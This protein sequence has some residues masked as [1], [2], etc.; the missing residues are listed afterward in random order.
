MN[1]P[2]THQ[3]NPSQPLFRWTIARKISGLASVLILFILIIVVYSIA[4]LKKIRADLQEISELDVPL[5][6]I[7]NAIEIHQLEQHIALDKLLE[8]QEKNSANYLN[9][10]RQI[11]QK[12]LENTTQL[13]KQLDE[14][15]VLSNLG[16]QLESQDKF[17]E[18]NR[19]LLVLQ[20][21]SNYLKNIIKEIIQAIDSKNYPDDKIIISL[22]EKDEIIDAQAI[23]L[24]KAVEDFTARRLI[25]AEKHEQTFLIINTG[26]GIAAL[27]LGILL[28]LII[29][30][31]IKSNIF[32]LSK[33][34]SEVRQAITEKK[35]ISP[36]SNIINSS[37][38]IGELAE[39]ISKTIENFSE[40]INQR[41][42][43]SQE[44]KKIATT[45]ALTGAF[46]RVKWEE[47]LMIEIDKAH[48]NKHNLSVIIFDIDFFKKI[49]DTYG[50]DV[51]DMVLIEV[52]AIATQQIRNTDSLYRIGGEE[53]TIL[54]PYTNREQILVLA[55]RVRK[56]IESHIF[57][58]V[59][60]ITISMGVTQ[61]KESDDPKQF[62]KRADLALYKSKNS[63]RNQV[64]TYF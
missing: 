37:D 31:S 38:E 26:L 63:G 15:I 11:I 42:R 13:E 54:S 4:S 62:V 48:Q 19:S 2:K 55:E 52:V 53:F 45:D 50:H 43:L 40:E 41:D 24:I 16:L 51:G 30:I 9:N 3:K 35:S 27:L 8:L 6:E 49:N 5:T 1:L 17:A 46:N 28:S 60:H 44:L 21:E 7:S 23:T 12:L 20:K 36:T 14:G 10:K 61:L 59:K 57:N 29:I 32:R 33:T 56:A 64:N 25:M 39:E 58:Q 34:I 22:L 18:I 47:M